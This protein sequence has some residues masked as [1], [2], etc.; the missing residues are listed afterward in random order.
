MVCDARASFVPASSASLRH[1]DR[2]QI[3]SGPYPLDARASFVPASSASSR[4]SGGVHTHPTRTPASSLR[5]LRHCVIPVEPKL[6]DATRPTHERRALGGLARSYRFASPD[7]RSPARVLT[8]GYFTQV[9][10][11]F[12]PGRKGALC[13]MDQKE[14]ALVLEEAALNSLP[15]S[16]RPRR[17]PLF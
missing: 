1:S 10:L 7:R 9:R 8:A 12:R 11:I 16:S 5:H 17:R 13:V 2:A 6:P 3:A 4:H 15:G 14:A